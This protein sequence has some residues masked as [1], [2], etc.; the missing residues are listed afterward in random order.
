MTPPKEDQED[1]A[2]LSDDDPNN[3]SSETEKQD[4]LAEIASGL[5]MNQNLFM[6]PG[7]T[8]DFNY[9]VQQVRGCENYSQ[10][11]FPTF[12]FYPKEIWEISFKDWQVLPA[13][14]FQPRHEIRE[15]SSPPIHLEDC[16]P[17]EME[18]PLE[19]VAIE[20]RTSQLRITQMDPL[21]DFDFTGPLI[22]LLLYHAEKGEFTENPARKY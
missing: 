19:T 21:P 11:C 14:A 3:S 22:K 4:L 7:P 8:Y 2:H 17:R 6:P 1:H 20:N 9:D 15:G 12:K 5:H 16:S 18:E 13:E 10:K